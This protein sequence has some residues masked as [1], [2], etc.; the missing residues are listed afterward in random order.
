MPDSVPLAQ[1]PN[2]AAV[3]LAKSWG[4]PAPPEDIIDEAALCLRSRGQSFERIALVIGLVDDRE[5]AAILAKR[6][7]DVSVLDHLCISNSR[8]ASSKQR[9]LALHDGLPFLQKLENE[10]IELHPDL[11][12]NKA[13]R[14]NC[15]NYDA[16]LVR[17]QDSTPCLV[18]SNWDKAY[19]KYQQAAG[20]DRSRQPLYKI[21]GLKV[22]ISVNTQVKNLAATAQ[23][24]VG[25]GGDEARR[26]MGVIYD[27]V[28]REDSILRKLAAVHDLALTQNSSDIHIDPDNDGNIHVTHRVWGEIEDLPEKLDLEQYR[29]IKQFLLQKSGANIKFERLQTPKDG[30]YAYMGQKN[31]YVRCSYIPLGTGGSRDLVSLCLRLI[32]VERGRVNLEEKRV[33]AKTIE[34][35]R[36]AMTPDAGMVLVVGPTG[37]GKST[38][39]SGA[40]GLHEDLHGISKTRF[41]IEDPIERFLPGIVQFQV[42]YALRGK[43]EGFNVLLRNLLRHDPNMIWVGEI[44]D[45]STAEV[46]VQAAA[47][48]HLLISTLHADSAVDAVDRLS[49]LIPPENRALRKALIK[50]LSLIVAQR[51]VRRLCKCAIEGPPA[52]ED[53]QY[54]RYVNEQRRLELT[55]PQNVHHPKPGGC[56]DCRDGPVP[57]FAGIVPVNDVLPVGK[58]AKKILMDIDGADGYEELEKLL[59]LRMEE[60]IMELVHKGLTPLGSIKY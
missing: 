59:S 32:P 33:H 46:S 42:P 10:H 31:V 36:F 11:Y 3:E 28:L 47:T 14:E 37:S 50:N 58:Q 39:V 21:D 48:G 25:E 15:E 17:L 35:L 45:A 29:A 40:I 51:L 9:I 1:H 16:V 30:M 55:V 22:A 38:T 57:G 18:F 54:V 56:P 49:N 13:L 6:R 53:V 12:S 41:S 2:P 60:A 44:R 4:W 27:H 52:P 26:S 5:M 7:D 23:S 34:A 43:P 24:G 20:L 8:I 19:A